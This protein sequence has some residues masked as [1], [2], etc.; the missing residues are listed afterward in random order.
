[1]SFVIQLQSVPES[2]RDLDRA[3]GRDADRSQHL[4]DVVEVMLPGVIG[5][6]PDHDMT[7]GQR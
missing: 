4:G 1:M 7:P 6:P 3:D 5:V 2:L